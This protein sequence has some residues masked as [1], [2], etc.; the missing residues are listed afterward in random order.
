ME[1]LKWLFGYD[2]EELRPTAQ[3]MKQRHV[4]LCQIKK[5]K[6][7]LKPVKKDVFIEKKL[8][9]II[10]KK[11][12]EKPRMDHMTELKTTLKKRHK[13]LNSNLERC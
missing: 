6:M 1:T 8:T 11:K 4:L 13:R 7:K 9:I 5:S 12:I 2:Y 10:K 3:T